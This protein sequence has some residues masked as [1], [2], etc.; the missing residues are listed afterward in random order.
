M[1]NCDC[2]VENHMSCAGRVP[3]FKSL[4]KKELR[5]V[6]SLIVQKEYGKKS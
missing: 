5:Q 3:I 1:A 2:T 4:D 6:V